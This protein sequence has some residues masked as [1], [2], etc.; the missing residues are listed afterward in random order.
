MNS[1]GS[2]EASGSQKRHRELQEAPGASH[3]NF[4]GLSGDVEGIS[5]GLR[6]R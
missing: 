4:R 1:R 5:G 2:Q 6:K 3:G